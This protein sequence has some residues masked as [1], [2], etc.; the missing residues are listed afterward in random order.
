MNNMFVFDL[1]AN[2]LN[3][4]KIHCI[5]A[6]DLS[7]GKIKKTT[8]YDNMRDFFSDPT[9]ILIAHNGIRYDKPTAERVLG[10]EVK[11]EMVDTLALSYYLET[12]RTIHGLEAWGE[13]F[14]I[15]K[16]VITDWESLSEEEYLHRVV[17]DV[18]INTKLW[19]RFWDSLM[20]LYGDEAEA[21]RLIR[22]L[23]FKFTCAAVQEALK[24]KLD[25]PKCEQ[26]LADLTEE[27]T[28]KTEQLREAMPPVVKTAMKTKPLKMYTKKGDLSVVG[29]KWLD[30]L[31]SKGLP[32]DY[33]EPVE[34]IISYKEPN[35]GS[36]P[37][38]KAWLFS[39]GWEPTTFKYVRDKDTNEFRTIPQIADKDEDDGVCASVK[40][41]FDR[42]PKLEVLEG[43]TVLKH[44]MGILKGFLDNVDDQG[45]ITAG[46]QGLTNTLRFRHKIFV[47]LPGIDKPYGDLIRGCLSSCDGF[48][49][50]GSD[51][52][53]LENRTG[54]HYL[55][56]YDPD[57]VKLKAQDGFDPHIQMALSAGLMTEDEAEF[58]KWYD[59][60]H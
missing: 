14:G 32:E 40:L 35:P 44:R 47:N 59:K 1:E 11:C 46:I 18:K 31:S 27:H 26:G 20:R 57:Y 51:L 34:D 36:V 25:I 52:A 9:R 43:L 15:P 28:N 23:S 60:N 53:S 37:Q 56:Q 8:S 2:G 45:F 21:W 19:K 49:L 6:C 38:L 13:F 3:A 42:E 54:D 22:Y 58:Y 7:T 41:L 33:D 30:L 4:D 55:Y 12:D 24:W 29:Q 17:E 48:E 50:C 16:P 5:A 39:L 10:V